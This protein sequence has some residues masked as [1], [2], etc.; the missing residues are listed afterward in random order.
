M[1][2]VSLYT[3]VITHIKNN[4]T[5]IIRGRG[6][7]YLAM[8]RWGGMP[9]DIGFPQGGRRGN[10]ESACAPPAAVL[11]LWRDRPGEGPRTVG[12]VQSIWIRHLTPS[13]VHKFIPKY[14]CERGE[15]CLSVSHICISFSDFLS[16][17]S[18]GRRCHERGQRGWSGYRECSGGWRPMFSSSKSNVRRDRVERGTRENYPQQ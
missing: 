14:Y 7:H 6:R 10:H 17:L 11:P 16:S 9:Q 2:L 5:K 8:S 4:K 15:L 12:A 13:D 3:S 1:V 18:L